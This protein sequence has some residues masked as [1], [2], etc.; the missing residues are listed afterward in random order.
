M[1]NQVNDQIIERRRTTTELQSLDERVIASVL[2]RSTDDGLQKFVFN[3]DGLEVPACFAKKSG[4]NRLLIAFNGAVSRS[5][6]PSGLVFQRSSWANEIDANVLFVSDPTLLR[7]TTLQLGWGQI[8]QQRFLPFEVMRLVHAIE[9]VVQTGGSGNRLYYGSSAGGFQAAASATFDS[10]SSV[11][12]NN[13]QVNWLNYTNQ[14]AVDKVVTQVL[15]FENKESLV[16]ENAWRTSLTAL[17]DRYET[18]PRLHYAVNVASVSDYETHFKPLKDW[19]VQQ[20]RSSR[21]FSFEKYEDDVLGHNPL[22][23]AESL[24]LINRFLGMLESRT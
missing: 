4:S 5:K 24:T 9:P 16:R 3:V 18:A 14:R 15:G 21:R 17:F 23:K 8:N 1:G 22:P 6:S 7:H 13:P 12:V 19:F 2:K 20:R 10:G 11:V